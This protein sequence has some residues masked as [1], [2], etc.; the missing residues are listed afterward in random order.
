MLLCVLV[1]IH[2]TLTFVFLS[3]S[4]PARSTKFNFDSKYL[5]FD[6]SREWVWKRK[7][8]DDKHEAYVNKIDEITKKP[9]EM[10]ERHSII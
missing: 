7:C 1:W 9:E 8:E 2:Y 4:E 3:R 6:W 10:S 5:A